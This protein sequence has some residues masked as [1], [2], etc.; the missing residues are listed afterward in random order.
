MN[1]ITAELAH[2]GN[3]ASQWGGNPPAGLWPI[4]SPGGGGHHPSFYL[5]PLCPACGRVVTLQPIAAPPQMRNSQGFE[6]YPGRRLPAVCRVGVIRSA[7]CTSYANLVLPAAVQIT[8]GGK[9]RTVS[10]YIAIWKGEGNPVL[11]FNATGANAALIPFTR[12]RPRRAKLALRLIKATA[13]G[14]GAPGYI[15]DYAGDHAAAL[16]GGCRLWYGTSEWE[17]GGFAARAVLKRLPPDML[18]QLC[19]FF[20]KLTMLYRLHNPINGERLTPL[21]IRR[22]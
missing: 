14:H 3:I 5:M 20:D 6:F 4:V 16:A 19:R 22:R 11:R 10:G 8:S 2:K 18:P 9:R 17:Q 13:Y 12:H 21:P 7:V 1:R 15:W